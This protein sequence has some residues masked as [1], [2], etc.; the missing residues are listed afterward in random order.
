MIGIL[1]ALCIVWIIVET[2]VQKRR[3]RVTFQRAQ[4]R[5]KEIDRTLVVFGDPNAGVSSL[6]LGRD[7]TCGDICIDKGGCYCQEV[8][9]PRSIPDVLS[10]I[11]TDS[12]VVFVSG[13]L[14]FVE[15]AH[16]EKVLYDLQ[17]ISG[18]GN[19]F[20]VEESPRNI[21]MWAYPAF[22]GHGRYRR[23]FTAY[24]PDDTEFAWF[25]IKDKEAQPSSAARKLEPVGVIE[26]F[27]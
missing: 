12:C 16:I 15:D 25:S 18:P 21:W 27:I 26:R 14:S 17:R 3:R 22:L 5:A 24:P 13:V 6:I 7:Y 11:P 10:D 1:F 23:S 8:S 20:V 2:L 19:L 4:Q 9:V